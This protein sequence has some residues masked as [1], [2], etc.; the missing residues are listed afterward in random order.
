MNR[1]VLIR[2]IAV[3]LLLVG[4]CGPQAQPTP[5]AVP[6]PPQAP[7]PVATT[8]P[9][10]TPKPAA[11]RPAVLPTPQLKPNG[12][13]D[14]NKIKIVTSFPHRGSSQGQADSIFNAIQMAVEEAGGKAG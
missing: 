11:T 9:R 13:G 2:A 10:P 6:T 12:T 7:K 4:A 3:G 14:L 8:L 5:S 1:L